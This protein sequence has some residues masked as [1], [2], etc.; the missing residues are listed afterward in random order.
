MTDASRATVDHVVT[1]G[2]T[3]FSRDDGEIVAPER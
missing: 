3:R 2:L 1:E